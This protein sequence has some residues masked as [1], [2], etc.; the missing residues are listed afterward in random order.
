MV[1]DSVCLRAN[2][3][4]PGECLNAGLFRHLGY[5]FGYAHMEGR[6]MEDSMPQ[7]SFQIR[8][9][10]L[11]GYLR[12]TNEKMDTV[13][14]PEGIKEIGNHAMKEFECTR[15]VMPRSLKAI[16][17]EAF[18]FARIKEI[19][20]NHCNLADIDHRAFFGCTAKTVLPDSLR[21]LGDEAI[22][23]L[24]LIKGQKLRLPSSLSYIGYHAMFLGGLRVLEVDERLVTNSSGLED[25]I[26]TTEG[27]SA[28]WLFLN[29]RRDGNLVCRVPFP[30][31]SGCS[32]GNFIDENGF[33]G[34]AF[35]D[36]FL[37]ANDRYIKAAIAAFR[38]MF[39]K[40]LTWTKDYRNYALY[41]FSFL[42]DSFEEDVETIKLYTEAGLITAYRL[43]KLLER[44]RA[45]R[46]V[47]LV[48]AIMELL[49]FKC[50]YSAKILRL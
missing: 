44:A 30:R 34:D 45:K 9:K 15:L 49:D 2:R 23:H 14:L 26:M 8:D 16:R 48:A 36:W 29:V 4:S 31:E 39:P 10:A 38:V 18:A 42:L 40:N 6:K 32:K 19:D 17:Y 33:N 28:G 25:L 11:E 5:D 37:R 24:D 22:R 12:N 20:F 43:R 46:N 13:I 47:E 3:P 41:N 21:C 35:D 1:P 27:H 7:C 50:G